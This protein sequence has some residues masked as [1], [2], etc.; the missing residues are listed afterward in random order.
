MDKLK[1][2]YK[3]IGGKEVDNGCYGMD[4]SKVKGVW[5]LTKTEVSYPKSL[6]T[7]K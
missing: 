5:V 2:M 4:T 7:F 6:F 3:F 1:K